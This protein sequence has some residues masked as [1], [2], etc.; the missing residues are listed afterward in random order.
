M[1]DS[2]LFQNLSLGP[3]VLQNR[4]VL[5]PLTRSRAVLSQGIFQMN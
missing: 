1:K 5:P 4:I 2:K 3:Y